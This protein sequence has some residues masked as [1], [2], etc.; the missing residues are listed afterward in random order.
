MFWRFWRNFNFK[1]SKFQKSRSKIK[2]NFK[3]QLET[4]TNLKQI[5]GT[6]IK[7]IKEILKI[8]AT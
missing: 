1:N 2:V 4:E 7:K 5:F 3:N 8:F 6:Q